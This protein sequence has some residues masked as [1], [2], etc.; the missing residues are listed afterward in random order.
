MEEWVDCLKVLGTIIRAQVL[1][2]S[3]DGED[4]NRGTPDSKR[5]KRKS[6]STYSCSWSRRTRHT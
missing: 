2:K 4:D 1:N 3:N 6:S 5:N